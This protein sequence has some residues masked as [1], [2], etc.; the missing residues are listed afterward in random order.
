VVED[1]SVG[2]PGPGEVRIDV[3]ACAIC[4]SDVTYADGAW[5]GD[6]P[7]IYGHEAAGVIESVGDGVVGVAV[8]DRVIVGLLRTC[9]GG[10]HC[11]RGED[12][13]CIGE[14]ADVSPFSDASGASILRGLKTGAFA[15][16]TVVHESQ[17]VPIPDGMAMASA[18]LLG[19][20]VLTGFG[21]VTNAAAMPAGSSAVI[22]G[23]GGVGLGTIQGA[24]HSGA[25]KVIAVDLIEDK[26]ETARQFGATHGVNGRDDA[27]ETVR[28]LTDGIGP[29]FVFVT[30]GVGTVIDQALAMV[31]RGGAVV[32][33][34]MPASGVMT[35]FETVEMADAAQRIIGSKMG[36]ARM[37][38]DVP[39]LIELYEQG[40]LK[41]DEMVSN[42]YPLEQ[43]NEAIAEVKAGTVVRNVVL[44]GE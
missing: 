25:S 16:Q 24:A 35:E 38:V 28:A 5:G 21:A 12:N 29:D 40:S 44:F 27:I 10:Y 1:I 8:G 17:V 11:I 37:S 3:E 6:T 14:F 7:A 33:V 36:S 18:S 30:V 43:I 2:G 42:T 31:R 15:E 4:H 22:I 19:C 20:G 39:R 34:G 9:G 32:M 26:L 23:I 13:L 41:L